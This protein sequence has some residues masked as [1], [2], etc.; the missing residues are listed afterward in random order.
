V[1]GYD[2]L[3]P[4]KRLIASAG[5][6]APEWERRALALLYPAFVLGLTKALAI[7]PERV[8][9]AGVLVAAAFDAVDAAGDDSARRLVPAEAPSAVCGCPAR[10]A[11]M[12]ERCGSRSPS[13]VGRQ[14][15]K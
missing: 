7:S 9:K 8:A 15:F 3:L 1:L 6:R 14:R 13:D 10:L 2:A 12:N 5:G 4:H 11:R